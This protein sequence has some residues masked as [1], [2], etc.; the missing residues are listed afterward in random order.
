M[1]LREARFLRNRLTQYAL[2][3]ISGVPQSQI[4]AFEKG[5]RRPTLREKRL[6]ERALKLEGAIDWDSDEG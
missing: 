6:I 5:Y 3:K 4:S 2:E 1:N